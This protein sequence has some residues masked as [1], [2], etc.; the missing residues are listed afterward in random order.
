[1]ADRTDV[2]VIGGGQAG[3]SAAYFLQRFG[4]GDRYLLLDHAPGPGGAWQFRWPTLTLASANRVHDL[5]GL[6]LIEAL[7]RDCDTFPAATAVPEYFGTYEQRFG[8]NIRRPVSVRT[9]DYA[10][11]GFTVTLDDGSVIGARAIINATGTWERPFVPHVPGIADFRGRQLHT[12]D[13]VGPDEFAGRRVLV[14]GAGISAV[15]LLIEIARNAPGVETFWCSRSEPVFDDTPFDPEKGRRAVA[16]VEER[17]RAGLPP[18]S[19]VSVTGLALTPSIAAARD[20]GILAWRRMFT[21]ITDTG[22]CW[23]CG[24]D[25][26]DHLDVDVIFWNTGFRSSLDHLAPLRLRS[27][28]GGITMTGR[29]ATT[30]ADEP[31]VQLLGYGPSASTIGANRA[32]REAAR[33]VADILASERSD[34]NS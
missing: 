9:V 4:L 24:T 8:L 25:G 26:T 3:L 27:A 1:M 30:V 22:V 28:G 20:D 33:N 31:R 18:T 29:L 32:G 10:D 11:D 34:A 17:V 19:V 12:H 21:R 6:G 14:V 13:Y 16:R 7:G 23:D 5:P 15:Q 2:V